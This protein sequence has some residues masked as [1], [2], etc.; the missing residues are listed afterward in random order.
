M[1]LSV[2][3]NVV[4]GYTEPRSVIS[5]EGGGGRPTLKQHGA[6]NLSNYSS[7][8]QRNF[9]ALILHFFTE[10]DWAR[11]GGNWEASVLCLPP[12]P[13]TSP[14]PNIRIYIHSVLC[15]DRTDISM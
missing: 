11:G 13:L 12:P 10:A 2:T 1:L 9:Y 8:R 7:N 14:L 3:L 4:R 15:N 6:M 5:R